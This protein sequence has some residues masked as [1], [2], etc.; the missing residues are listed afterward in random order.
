MADDRQGPAAT[1][2]S[3]GTQQGHS[4]PRGHSDAFIP[5]CLFIL[6]S[7]IIAVLL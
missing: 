4:K 1:R 6:L 7:G 5:V 2:S 3:G